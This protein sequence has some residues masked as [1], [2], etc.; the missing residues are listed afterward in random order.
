MALL[1]ALTAALA[2]HL[3]LPCPGAPGAWPRGAENP[4]HTCG[5]SRT[6]HRG[7]F[8]DLN[9]CKANRVVKGRHST[10]RVE[11]QGGGATRV[12]DDDLNCWVRAVPNHR[13]ALVSVRRWAEL[14]RSDHTLGMDSPVE[15]YFDRARRFFPDDTVERALYAHQTHPQQRTAGAVARLGAAA[16]MTGEGPPSH[17]R[18]ELVYGEVEARGEPEGCMRESRLRSFPQPDRV[19]ELKRGGHWKVSSSADDSPGCAALA[20]AAAPVQ[21]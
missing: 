8:D 19:A 7:P 6:D 5:M 13:R 9:Q 21:L 10:A 3:P 1:I 17:K 14:A 2:R 11:S 20:A 18:L 15:R 16:T 12:I 4:N